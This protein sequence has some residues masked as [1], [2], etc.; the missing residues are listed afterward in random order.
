M[1]W[2]EHANTK[3]HVS[4]HSWLSGRVILSILAHIAHLAQSYLSLILSAIKTYNCSWF[5]L[6]NEKI[7]SDWR[8]KLG[9]K[10][11]MLVTSFFLTATA[12]ILG[13][14][15]QNRS[16]LLPMSWACFALL[17]CVAGCKPC[18]LSLWLGLKYCYLIDQSNKSYIGYIIL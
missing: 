2:C 13:L 7:C 18:R 15:L 11:Q 10:W 17:S 4:K 8:Q 16:W 3:K 6:T 12:A 9:E 14:V 5:D 1:F